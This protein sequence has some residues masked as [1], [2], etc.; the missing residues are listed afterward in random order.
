MATAAILE[1]IKV[2][3]RIRFG[4]TGRNCSSKRLMLLKIN[5]IAVI[6]DVGMRVIV[7]SII[8][9]TYQV[10]VPILM[11]NR[12]SIILIKF[13]SSNVIEQS[14]P[15]MVVCVINRLSPALQSMKLNAVLYAMSVMYGLNEGAICGM[16]Q[17]ISTYS[18]IRARMVAPRIIGRDVK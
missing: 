11:E 5:E 10:S 16:C 6:D 12:I 13:N 18:A 3:T 15:G 1:A 2:E 8:K 14:I 4:L 9:G 7:L 17:L